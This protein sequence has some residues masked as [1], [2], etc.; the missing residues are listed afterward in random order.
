MSMIKNPTIDFTT[1]GNVRDFELVYYDSE[2]TL[3]IRPPKARPGT[4]LDWEGELWLRIDLET[5]EIVGLEIEDFE[6]VF[7]KKYPD[8]ALAWQ[9]IKPICHRRNTNK[10][11]DES[12]E[13]FLRILYDFLVRFLNN[14]PTQVSLGLA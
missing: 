5:H 14:N 12:C 1:L 8:L 3:F 11:N 9:E 10:Y 6:S 13:S 4:S 7:L 2:D